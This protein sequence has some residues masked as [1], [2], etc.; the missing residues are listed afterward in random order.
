MGRGRKP[1]PTRLKLITGNPGCR[2]LPALEP[3]PRT[4]LP[5]APRHLGDLASAEW[6][7]MAKVLHRLGVLTETDLA[8]LEAYCVAYGRW[9]EAEAKVREL[10]QVVERKDGKT[11]RSPWLQAA[12]EAMK[13]MARLMVEF[14]LTPSSRT[15][16]S[17]IEDG[18]G[19][20]SL[21]EFLDGPAEAK[22]E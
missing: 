20:D 16:V 4:V 9:R 21:D 8:G 13:L 5:N 22:A 2:P 7:R 14:G 1:K 10:G 18:G 15:K 17:R 12:N 3:Q 6:R 19:A 11:L